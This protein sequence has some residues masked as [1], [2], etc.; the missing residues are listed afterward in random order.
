MHYKSRLARA[1]AD[2]AQL[3]AALALAEAPQ[4]EPDAA[5]IEQTI[6]SWRQRAGWGPQPE[7]TA[8][9]RDELT[10]RAAA[11]AAAVTA[12]EDTL[13]GGRSHAWAFRRA[14][15]E[16]HDAL[17]PITAALQ[18]RS[19]RWGA[20][21]DDSHGDGE[22]VPFFRLIVAH[23][24]HPMATRPSISFLEAHAECTAAGVLAARAFDAAISGGQGWEE[25]LEI[26]LSVRHEVLEPLYQQG[27]ARV[28]TVRVDG[29]PGLSD[30]Q[31]AR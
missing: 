24:D 13:A 30:G 19:A 28:D 4:A 21:G 7:D 22:D 14:E 5:T 23:F 3:T 10:A 12:F 2:I 29:P 6:Q 9:V 11:Y 27:L 20:V 26:A 18:A 15:D 1:S 16:L 31:V 8:E 25:A 17:A